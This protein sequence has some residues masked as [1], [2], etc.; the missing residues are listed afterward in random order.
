MRRENTGK[1]FPLSD[2]DETVSKHGSRWHD[3]V[4]VNWEY[5]KGSG[6]D[7]ASHTLQKFAWRYWDKGMKLSRQDNRDLNPP[8]PKYEIG[9]LWTLSRTDYSAVCSDVSMNDTVE[10]LKLPASLN[11]SCIWY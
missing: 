6:H 9:T 7:Q 1:W 3:I 8:L 4:A 11:A 2:S 5:A 10:A